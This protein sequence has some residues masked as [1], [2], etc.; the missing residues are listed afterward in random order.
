MLKS[1]KNSHK[2]THGSKVSIDWF[3]S[4]TIKN[5][6]RETKRNVKVRRKSE[7]LRCYKTKEKFS[8]T[9]GDIWPKGD[10]SNA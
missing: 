9:L 3:G 7:R 10:K 1:F 4:K 8:P 2:T 5:W 6:K